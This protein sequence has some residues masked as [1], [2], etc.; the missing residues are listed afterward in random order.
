MNSFAKATTVSI[1][2]FSVALAS[3]IGM[4][5]EQQTMAILTGTAVGFFI[6]G[7][8]VVVVA[9]VLIRKHEAK[10]RDNNERFVSPM[11]P[12][13]P[14]NAYMQMHYNYAPQPRMMPQQM[15]PVMAMPYP[16]LMPMQMGQ[17]QYAQM[18]TAQAQLFAPQRKFFMIGSEGNQQEIVPAQG[19]VIDMF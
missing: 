14:N 7:A 8:C 6:A 17:N 13:P 4:R 5:M 3:V 15:P 16:M 18:Q 12:S 9:L 2:L 10:Q 11:P 1:L 19:E